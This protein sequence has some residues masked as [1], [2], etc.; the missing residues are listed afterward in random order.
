MSDRRGQRGLFSGAAGWAVVLSASGALAQAVPAPNPS[1]VAPTREQ[2]NPGAQVQAA[3]RKRPS[4]L[5]SA[6][7]TEPCALPGDSSLSFTLTGVDVNGTK[8]LSSESLHDVASDMIGRQ[9]TPADLCHIRDR[10]A[11]RLFQKSILAR[12]VIPKQ[13]INGGR[14]A[15]T[16]IEAQIVSVRYHGDIGPVQGKVEAYLNHLRGLAKSALPSRAARTA[17]ST[18]PSTRT[19]CYTG[20]GSK[21]GKRT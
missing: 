9:I 19:A 4:D 2:M 21:A 12:V 7:P 20:P 1:Q 11:A 13:Q 10:I 8:V 5:F 17:E 15:F 3:A 14:V 16:V 18:T 6:P